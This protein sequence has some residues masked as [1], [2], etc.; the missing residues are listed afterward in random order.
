MWI[1]ISSDCFQRAV[2]SDK[3]E[4]T[5]KQIIFRTYKTYIRSTSQLACKLKSTKQFILEQIRLSLEVH[6][7]L[8][9]N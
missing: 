9:A 1:L 7:N 6:L 4:T 8:H 5:S 2:N 3:N